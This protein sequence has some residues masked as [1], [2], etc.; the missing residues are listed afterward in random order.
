MGFREAVPGLRGSDGLPILAL[1][2]DTIMQRGYRVRFLALGGMSLCYRGERDGKAFFLKEVPGDRGRDVMALNQEKGLL[3]RLDH[4]SIV[5]VH[6]LFE[7]DGFYYLVLDFVAGQSLDRLVSPFPDTFLQDAVVADWGRQL[8]DVLGYLHRQDPVVIYR[9]LKP[10]NVLKDA[11]GRLHLVDFGIARLYKEGQSRDTEALGSALTASPE[12]YS[13]QTDVRSD[14]YSLGATLHYLL[15]NGRARRESPFEFAPV[16]EVNP[17]VSPALEQVVMKALALAPADRFQSM[18][19]MEKAL[20]GGVVAPAPRDEPAVEAVVSPTPPWMWALMGALAMAVV[21]G[22]AWLNLPPAPQ[23]AVVASPSAVVEPS[24]GGLPVVGSGTGTGTE[25]SPAPAGPPPGTERSPAPAGSHPGTERSP[26]VGPHPGTE[27]SPAVGPLPG[28]ERSPAVG[29]H[30]GTERSPAVGP[31][32][33]TE[34]SPAVGPH[35]GTERSPAVGPLPGTDGSPGAAG[36]RPGTERSPAL[37]AVEPPADT[38]LDWVGDL[39][40]TEM[41]GLQPVAGVV[42]GEGFTFEIEPDTYVSNSESGAP[43]QL[44]ITRRP[45]QPNWMRVVHVRK[46]AD[47][48]LDVEALGQRHLDLARKRDGSGLSLE[49]RGDEVDLSFELVLDQARRPIAIRGRERLVATPSGTYSIVVMATVDGYPEHAAELQ[50]I[51]RSLRTD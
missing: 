3:E 18:A 42:Q 28:T 30:P 7:E 26:A 34:R 9:D 19:E 31:H 40:R 32:P 39:R 35:P 44:C 6:Q 47:R 11:S 13:G 17:R 16:R 51:L 12:H 22:V 27:R 24:P 21:L 10:R 4:P 15:T 43:D 50:Q 48:P 38:L 8:C 41:R 20:G 25:R 1:P 49:R 46:V 37:A 29:P 5:R 36:P 33:G 14:V 45:R 2:P 23:V